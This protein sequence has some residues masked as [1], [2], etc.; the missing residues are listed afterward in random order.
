[1]F[2]LEE[3]L[4]PAKDQAEYDLTIAETIHGTSDQQPVISVSKL[5]YLKEGRRA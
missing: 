5:R 3:V 4:V 2:S 1:V